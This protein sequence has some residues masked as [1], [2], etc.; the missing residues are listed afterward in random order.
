MFTLIHDGWGWTISIKRRSTNQGQLSVDKTGR[1]INGAMMP[2]YT[3]NQRSNRTNGCPLTNHHRLAKPTQRMEW[4]MSARTSYSGERRDPFKWSKLQLHT[5]LFEKEGVSNKVSTNWI[6]AA[7][8]LKEHSA[9]AQAPISL[10]LYNRMTQEKQKE[11]SLEEDSHV[12]TST[13]EYAVVRII[14]HKGRSWNRK[15]SVIQ[16]GYEPKGNTLKAGKISKHV[17]TQNLRRVS[18]WQACA[19]TTNLKQ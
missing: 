9:A 8:G 15:G 7:L 1:I 5:I 2:K 3:S 11:K 17:I 4:Q 16:Y 14:D 19:Q 18:W 12:S 10:D 6:I 13:S